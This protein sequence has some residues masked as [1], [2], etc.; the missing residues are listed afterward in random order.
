MP[1]VVFLK[2]LAGVGQ[3]AFCFRVVRGQSECFLMRDH[4]EFV[5][6]CSVADDS[7]LYSEGFYRRGASLTGNCSQGTVLASFEAVELAFAEER[8][9]C[10]GGVV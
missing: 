8:L 5:A 1:P 6:L 9:P 10:G 4:Y 7:S 2:T 3:E